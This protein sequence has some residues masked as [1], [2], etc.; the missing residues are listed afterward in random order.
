ML[1]DDMRVIEVM[2]LTETAY[3]EV[4]SVLEENELEYVVTDRTPNAD[5]VEEADPEAGPDKDAVISPDTSAVVSFPLPAHTV[6]HVQNEIEDRGVAEH[7]YTVVN[8]PEAVVSDRLGEIEEPYQEIRG[9]GYQGISRSELHSKASDLMPDLTIYTLM[10][11]IS[12]VVA[13]A[14]VLLN[15]LAVLVG[16]MVIAPLIGPLM[17]TS[18]ATVIDD[19]ELFRQSVKFQG[20]GAAV[21]LV[22]SVA[23]AWI[24]RSTTLATVHVDPAELLRLSGY[25]APKG[26]LIVVALGAGFAGA[27]SLST[28]GTIDLVGVMIAAAVIP[29]VGVAGVG[30]AWVKPEVVL[31]ALT[32]VSVNIFAIALAAI[33]SLWY[34]GY[35]PQS[36]AELR[37]ARGTM[38]VRVVVLAVAI[39]LLVGLRASLATGLPLSLPI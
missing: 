18:V 12:A 4:V 5:R 39:L 15:S 21:G 22:S 26:L 9:L 16:A 20:L 7:V 29:P 3:G 10:T 37:K 36:W 32:I 19:A 38:L 2:T 35:H 34:L 23:F 24:V 27:L 11:A 14:G 6:E 8:D 25:A 31:G 13:T 30:V 28:S 33:I 17:A 1:Q